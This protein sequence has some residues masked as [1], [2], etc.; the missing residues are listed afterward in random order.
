MLLPLTVL[1]VDSATDL[2]EEADSKDLTQQI[3]RALS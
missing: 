2:P 1:R 3:C